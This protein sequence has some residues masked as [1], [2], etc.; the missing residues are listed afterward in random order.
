MKLPFIVSSSVGRKFV[1]S[2]SGAFLV[3]FFSFHAVMNVVAIISADAY[4]WICAALG[5]NWYAIL[6]TLVIVGGVVLHILYGIWLTLQNR[7]ARGTER[8]AVSKNP[9]GVAW[10]SR[11]MLVLGFV[12]LGG[13]AIHLVHFWSKMQLVELMGAHENSL[14]LSPQDGAALIAHTFTAWYNV[15]IYL[16]WFAALWLHLTHGMWSMFQS[17][18]ISNQTWLPRLKCI[19]NVWTTAVVGMFALVIIVF[20]IKSLI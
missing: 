14:G 5:A 4:N 16:V 10:S 8:Y 18:G 13:L 1:M 12:V 19:S 6:G 3:L 11:N 2:L 17:S 9:P 15:V 20:F 7:K